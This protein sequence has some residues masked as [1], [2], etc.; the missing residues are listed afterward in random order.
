MKPEKRTSWPISRALLIETF[1]SVESRRR[2]IFHRLIFTRI[3]ADK[4]TIELA[5]IRYCFWPKG[6]STM[7]NASIRASINAQRSF[8]R[9]VEEQETDDLSENFLTKYSRRT[10]SSVL[11]AGDK[12]FLGRKL[13]TLRSSR[14]LSTMVADRRNFCIVS[15][16]IEFQKRRARWTRRAS[17]KLSRRRTS[18]STD[19]TRTPRIPRWWNS[20]R[21]LLVRIFFLE[22]AADSSIKSF[23]SGKTGRSTTMR[24]KIERKRRGR[25][26][27]STYSR[28]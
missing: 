24:E 9:R 3:R 1:K 11:I 13:C 26:S 4:R 19:K 27:S 28:S 2:G 20:L 8:A 10:R 6:A 23:P 15:G 22:I 21:K 5:K 18:L 7:N 25:E 12:V 14:N 16:T 17:R